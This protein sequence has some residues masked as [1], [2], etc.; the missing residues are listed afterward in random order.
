[1]F[2]PYQG[3]L[4]TPEEDA[5]GVGQAKIM[6]AHQVNRGGGGWRAIALKDMLMSWGMGKSPSGLQIS[7]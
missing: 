3:R 2:S 6:E 5:M 4:M 1:M 7:P